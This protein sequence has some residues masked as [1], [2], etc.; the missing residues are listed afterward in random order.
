MQ[1]FSL[2]AEQLLSLVLAHPR[3]YGSR[4]TYDQGP[5]TPELPVGGEGKAVAAIAAE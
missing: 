4:T 3:P 2:R 5:A 1:Q